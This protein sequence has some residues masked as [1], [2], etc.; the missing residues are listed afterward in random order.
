MILN[1]YNVKILDNFFESKDFEELNKINLKKISSDQIKVYHNSISKNK[2]VIGESLSKE[3]ILRIH[4]K[5]HKIVFKLLEDLSPEKAKLYDYT[6]LVLIETGAKYKYPIHDDTPNKLLS[7]VIY[8]SPEKNCGTSFY[9][10]KNGKNKE[11]IE[12]KKNRAVF[13]S[14][15]ELT[16]WHSYEGDGVSNRIALVYNLNTKNIK[17][18]YKIENKS[19]LLGNF[20]YKIN[21][22]LFEFFKITI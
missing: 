19:Y 7:G 18:V 12:W 20:R 21:P 15:K 1:N 16:T 14:R 3:L 11:T 17:E 8:L 6:D 5:Y 13:F 2:S 10:S 4:D 22:Y 9:D